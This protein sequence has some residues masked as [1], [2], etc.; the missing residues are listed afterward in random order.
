MM[1]DEPCVH[2]WIYDHKDYNDIYMKCARC[3]A[4][5]RVEQQKSNNYLAR[6]LR[7]RVDGKDGDV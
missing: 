4:Y 5:K 1:P 6:L 2:V 3:G 7:I